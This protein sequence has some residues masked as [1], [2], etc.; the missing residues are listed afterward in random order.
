MKRRTPW[1]ALLTCWALILVLGVGV[2]PSLSYF[3]TYVTAEGGYDIVLKQV[4]S[5]LHEDYDYNAKAKNIQIENVGE[6][7]CY[8]RV[9]VL[10]G[11]TV[12]LSFSGDGWYQDGNYW[13]Y[14]DIV[15]P[16][17]ITGLLQAKIDH[18]QTSDREYN[19]I[20]I[21]ECTPVLYDKDGN[22]YADWTLRAEVA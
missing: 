19:V 21:S 6:V 12:G 18:D 11:S 22:P 1:T 14:R 15:K 17:E 16:G 7:D 4:K 13:Y 8:V 9:R 3:T 10:A 5:E 20:V 2:T